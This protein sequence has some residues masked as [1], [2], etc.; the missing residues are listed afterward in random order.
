MR[1]QGPVALCCKFRNFLQVLQSFRRPQT[2]CTQH[3]HAIRTTLEPVLL[4]FSSFWFPR[5]SSAFHIG[6]CPCC[7]CSAFWHVPNAKGHVRTELRAPPILE[8]ESGGQFG[9]SFQTPVWPCL[10]TPGVNESRCFPSDEEEHQLLTPTEA[11]WLIL[12][13]QMRLNPCLNRCKCFKRVL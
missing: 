11:V 6:N 13:L 3:L 5:S 2:I 7:K 8:R 4:G 9:G 1:C 12:K 10:V